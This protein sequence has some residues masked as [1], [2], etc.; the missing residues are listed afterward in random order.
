MGRPTVRRGPPPPKAAILLKLDLSK[1]D[2]EALFRQVDAD[3]SGA[4]DYEEFRAIFTGTREKLPFED[5]ASTHKGKTREVVATFN[6]ADAHGDPG[7]STNH[8][9]SDEKYEAA[10]I[11]ALL[12]RLPPP[13]MEQVAMMRETMMQIVRA[14]YWEMIEE[15]Q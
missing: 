13:N 5:D 15:G 7:L 14:E 11:E 3:D 9:E 2:A 1:E 12:R 4:I 10:E 8:Q 6:G